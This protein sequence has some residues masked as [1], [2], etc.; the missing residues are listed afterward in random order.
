MALAHREN[1]LF[2]TVDHV[3]DKFVETNDED[4]N[5]LFSI[6]D[7]VRKKTKLTG[8]ALHSNLF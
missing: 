1:N 3:T 2:A 4:G 8:L 7:V 6:F 5:V